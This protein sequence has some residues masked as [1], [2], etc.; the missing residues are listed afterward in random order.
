[1][2][3][4]MNAFWLLLGGAM[5]LEPPA[6]LPGTAPADRRPALQRQSDQ[7]RRALV[8]QDRAN[9]ILLTPDEAAVERARAIVL[10]KRT[11]EGKRLSQ[12]E[13][14]A[15]W[16]ATDR[17]EKE[18][19]DRLARQFRIEVYRSFRQR[20]GTVAQRRAALA[21]VLASWEAAGGSSGFMSRSW[22]I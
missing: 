15:L 6:V 4:L 8:R 9:Q 16:Q 12:A 3:I 2:T 5:L 13:L 10:L 1:M 19:I 11:V 18:A 21:R 14:D 22:T 7:V 17:R 20:R